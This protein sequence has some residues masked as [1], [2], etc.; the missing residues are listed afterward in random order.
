MTGF[1]V[2]RC[3]LCAQ[4]RIILFRRVDSGDVYGHCEECEQGYLSPDELTARGGHLTLLDDAD[5]EPATREDVERSVWAN[6]QS[7][8]MP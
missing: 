3:P 6:W 8:P 4:G 7:W 5:A 1:H 2:G